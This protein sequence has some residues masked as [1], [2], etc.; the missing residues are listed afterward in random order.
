MID[1]LPHFLYLSVCSMENRVD[2]MLLNYRA[3]I[4]LFN[5][6]KSSNSGG[7]LLDERP[8]YH[9]YFGAW[10]NALH[11]NGSNYSRRLCS[12]RLAQ[13]VAVA[14]MKFATELCLDTSTIRHYEVYFLS[15]WN[16]KHKLAIK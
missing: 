4:S 2:I 14:W 1:I 9:V 12:D 6:R 16:N 8:A 10:Y 7:R 5:E 13:G 11:C 15:N 3:Y